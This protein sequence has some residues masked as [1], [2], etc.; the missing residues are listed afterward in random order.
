MLGGPI[1]T[2][3]PDP[4]RGSPI[5]YILGWVLLAPY[6]GLAG[7]LVYVDPAS[8][9]GA[10][11]GY[12]VGALMVAVG[13]PMVLMLIATLRRSLGALGAAGA[14]GVMTLFVLA[15]LLGKHF[16]ERRAK[17]AELQTRVEELRDRTSSKKATGR[18]R[19]ED[20][21]RLVADIEHTADEVGDH[22]ADALR[23][24]ALT[25]RD[26]AAPG[27]LFDERVGEMTALHVLDA[28]KISTRDDLA[29]RLRLV[30][31]AEAAND[32]VEARVRDMGPGFERCMKA[33]DAPEEMIRGAVDVMQNDP[34]IADVI[35]F[36]VVE[37]R[38]LGA[39]R[40][41][42]TL[43]DEEWGR[44]RAN[45]DTLVIDRPAQ[46]DRYKQI[47]ATLDAA[48]RDEAELQRKAGGGST[49]L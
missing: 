15:G 24:A 20:V 27:R 22:D 4:P 37:R 17:I 47:K 42:L 36:R 48:T 25:I 44:W 10:H 5:P 1:V 32:A 31:D 34:R 39:M 19:A 33:R 11:R 40:A 13:L 28:A 14:F 12:V 38:V 8:G 3:R 23:C 41:M 35:A 46:L 9:K 7:L 30:A 43:F 49:P 2:Q 26:V 29:A 16:V 6:A 18:S 45:G 21:D